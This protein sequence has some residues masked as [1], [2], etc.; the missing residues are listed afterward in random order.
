MR[1]CLQ[2]GTTVK[3][4]VDW[5]RRQDHMEQ[6][7]AEHLLA[8]AVHEQAG[9]DETGWKLEPLSGSEDMLENTVGPSPQ[10]LHHDHV[11]TAPCNGS[12]QAWLA[13]GQG[14]ST[15]Q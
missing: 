5:E 4:V 10:L 11:A 2:P 9:A 13:A 8:A 15:G 6:H 3:V 1:L 7:T 14:R 12:Y